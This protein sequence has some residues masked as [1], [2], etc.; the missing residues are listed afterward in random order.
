MPEFYGGQAGLE[1]EIR[2]FYQKQLQSLPDAY[3]RKTGKTFENPPVMAATVQRLIEESLVTPNDRRCSMVDDY[4]ITAYPGVT[5]DFLDVLVDSRLL[6]KENRLDDFYYEIS[7]DTLLPVIVESRNSRRRREKAEQERLEYETKLAEE[8]KRREEVEG[9]LAAVRRQRRMARI[10]AATSLLFL[11]VTIGFGVWFVR[12]YINAA[13][14]QLHSAE[15]SARA[16]LYGAAVP[17]YK[18]LLNHPRRCWVL[19]HSKPPKIVADELRIAQRFDSLYQIVEDSL[20]QGDRLFFRDDHA[21]ALGSY[22]NAKNLQDNYN[23]L[24]WELSPQTDSGRVWR[25]DTARVT[26]KFGT[27]GYRIANA[28]KALIKEFKIHQ[29]DFEVFSEAK[30]WGQAMRNLER[31]QQLL[32]EHP[33]DVAALKRELNLDEEEPRAYVERETKRC[34][35]EIRRL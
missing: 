10:V 1:H 8:A 9:Q 11:M 22:Y 6:R 19:R 33:D 27:L 30:V 16:E 15:E 23:K 24:N 2:D 13:K 26:A 35:A 14:D 21:A 31:M 4:L 28:R 12:D 3:A 7:H 17:V 18:E 34:L 20:L 25:V 5:Q 29:R 32:P